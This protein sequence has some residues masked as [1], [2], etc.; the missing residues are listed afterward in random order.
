MTLP[1]INV[2][3]LFPEERAS[4]LSVLDSLSSQEW[5]LPT[6]CTGWSVKDIAL[7]ILGSEV[8]IISRFRDGFF[9]PHFADGLD[10]TNWDGLLTA[11][12]RQ[13]EYWTHATRRV[14]PELLRQ[15][16]RFTGDESKEVYR[17]M[18]PLALGG[19]V[20]WAGSGPAP[21]W[22]HMCR[23]YTER[24]VHQQHIRDA[25]GKPGFNDRRSFYPVLDAFARAIPHVLRNTSAVNGAIVRL[26]V[27]GEAGGEWMA[28]FESGSGWSLIAQHEDHPAMASVEIDQDLAWRLF[29]REVSPE[30]VFTKVQITGDHELAQL[31]LHMVSI[32]A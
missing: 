30:E 29:T 32:I 17:T 24:W 12:K 28:R 21:L 11:I 16:L 4:L 9:S 18:D 26:T 31:V 23:E 3:D 22:M 5:E 1:A 20:D 15:L 10:I 6:V 14:S 25:V 27:T 2:V 8:G 13:N 7:H 19:P